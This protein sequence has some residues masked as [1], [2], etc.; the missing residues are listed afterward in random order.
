MF[1]KRRSLIG[2]FSALGAAAFLVSAAPVGAGEIRI[3]LTLE[4]DQEVPP[5]DSGASGSAVLVWDG[6]NRICWELSIENV[7]EGDEV[8][9]AHIHQ[10]PAGQNGPIVFPFDPPPV[11]GHSEDCTEFDDSVLAD[12]FDDP[13]SYYVNIHSR[14]Y[15]NGIVRGQLG[16]MPDT[17]TNPVTSQEAGSGGLPL[18]PLLPIALATLLVISVLDRRRHLEG[19][20]RRR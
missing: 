12:I 15:P 16:I 19:D 20:P 2:M 7:P 13:A 11:D 6:E 3:E 5:N 1:G 10:A 17:A 14:E 8:V 18:L 9:A 4:D